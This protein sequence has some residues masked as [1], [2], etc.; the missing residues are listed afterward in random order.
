MKRKEINFS[1]EEKF[2]AMQELREEWDQFRPP[3][4]IDERILYHFCENKSVN[5]IVELIQKE[6]DTKECY[7]TKCWWYSSLQEDFRKTAKR[8]GM[9]MNCGACNENCI[10]IKFRDSGQRSLSF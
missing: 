4:E 5:E 8:I 3:Q 6:F 2:E 10:P 7:A 1:D 9:R